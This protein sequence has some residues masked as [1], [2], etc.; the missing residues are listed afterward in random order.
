MVERGAV[1]LR[2]LRDDFDLSW[3]EP[4]GEGGVLPDDAPRHQVVRGAVRAEARVVEG[5]GG[6]DHVPVDGIKIRE[7]QGVADHAL[8]M[9]ALVCLVKG[10][11]AG[12][13]LR[14][15]VSLQFCYHTGGEDTK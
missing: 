2:G 13:N 3:G 6:V 8:D 7:R 14:L 15:H 10:V 12:K 11:V 9:R 4:A 5:R 1:V